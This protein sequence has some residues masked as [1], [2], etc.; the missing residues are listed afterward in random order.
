MAGVVALL[1][2]RR[3]DVVGG[4]HHLR[5]VGDELRI[6]TEGPKRDD[7]GHRHTPGKE[8][9]HA[10][11]VTPEPE[12]VRH[13][14]VEPR[15]SGTPANLLGRLRRVKGK[16]DG[17]GLLLGLATGLS[18]LRTPGRCG[19]NTPARG[20]RLAMFLLTISSPY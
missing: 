17:L 18:P 10:N 4:R 14:K 5:H 12:M 20:A 19:S 2:V 8:K 3:D 16:A 1:R 9:G 6:V 7:L 15:T 11:R 13:T